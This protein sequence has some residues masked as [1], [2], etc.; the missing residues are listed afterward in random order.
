MHVGRHTFATGALSSGVPLEVVSEWLGHSD[1]RTTQ[2]YAK[3]TNDFMVENAQV[4]NRNL[5]K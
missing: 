5:F 4:L 2:I 1:I 3:I